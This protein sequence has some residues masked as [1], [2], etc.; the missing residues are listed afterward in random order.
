M[1]FSLL[2]KGVSTETLFTAAFNHIFT[3]KMA[4]IFGSTQEETGS[5]ISYKKKQSRKF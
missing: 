4:S 1:C 2:I 3:T 5:D